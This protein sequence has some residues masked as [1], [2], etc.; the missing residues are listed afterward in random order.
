[1]C[2]QK[3]DCEYQDDAKGCALKHIKKARELLAESKYQD[4]D[5]MLKYAE[6]HLNEM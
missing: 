2:K 4:A 5:I 1:M 3:K 6:Q